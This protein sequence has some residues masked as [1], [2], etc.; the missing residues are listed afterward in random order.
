MHRN[1]WY[2][3][4]NA[5]HKGLACLHLD[6]LP[7]RDG[8]RPDGTVPMAWHLFNLREGFVAASLLPVKYEE[9]KLNHLQA[10]SEFQ[11]F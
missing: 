5:V 6:S 3:G 9:E 7:T 8:L 4:H 11:D 10:E 2:W 1:D